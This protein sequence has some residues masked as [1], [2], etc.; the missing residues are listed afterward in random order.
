MKKL[1][2]AIMAVWALIK[3]ELEKAIAKQ[4]SK[5]A[6]QF[7]ALFEQARNNPES[8]TK[9]LSD[10]ISEMTGKLE[11]IHQIGTSAKYNNRCRERAK[12]PKSICSK[13]YAA[14]LLETAR[15]ANLA[16]KLER[17]TLLW[18]SFIIPVE[19]MPIINDCIFRF[20]S[21]GDL[22]NTIQFINYLHMCRRNP[23]TTFTI[24]TKNPDIMNL[25]FKMSAE[26]KPDNLIIVYSDHII[27][28]SGKKTIN[29]IL[30]KYA[31]IDKVF[32]VYEPDYARAHNE[33]IINCRNPENY[34]DKRCITCRNC[35]EHN[36]VKYIGEILK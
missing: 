29:T 32:T 21:F 9:L 6:A 36:N 24:W 31:F 16:L 4:T 12:N 20:E 17:N 22:I 7:R 2:N 3:S 1:Y 30:K 5:K 10:S 23:W 18:C 8:L 27:N 26:T 11:H 33:I 25:A 28:G 19:T 13:C 15:G 14:A 34:D 35:Y